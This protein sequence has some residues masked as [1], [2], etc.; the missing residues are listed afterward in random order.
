VG[1]PLPG[2]S[3]RITDPE[4]GSELDRGEIGMIEVRGPNVFQG[5]WKLP[6]RTATEFRDGYFITGDLGFIDPRGYVSICGRQKDL[7]IAGGFNVYP[8]EVEAVIAELDQVHEVAVIGVP[9]ADLGEGVVAVVVPR[10]PAF[11]DESALLELLDGHLARFKQPRRV[12]F[13][14]ELAKNAMGKVQKALLRER[15]RTLFGESKPLKVVGELTGR[16]A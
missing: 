5:Y 12:V 16:S 6:E 11:R 2:V 9:H 15:Y 7:I 10:D 8:A 4:N 13:V 3:I 1:P 14:P